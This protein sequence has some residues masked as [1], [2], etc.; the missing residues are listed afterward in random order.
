MKKTHFFLSCLLALLVFTGAG[1]YASPATPSSD[2]NTPGASSGSATA[3]ETNQVNIQGFTFS[4]VQVRVKKGTTVTFTNKDASQ[5]S[6]TADNG[7][8]DTGLLSNGESKTVTFDTVGTFNYH[9]KMHP[10]MRATIIV[11]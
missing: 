11:E 1:C 7:S 4:P 5:H 3:V 2:S 6:A 8:F 9:C 10:S